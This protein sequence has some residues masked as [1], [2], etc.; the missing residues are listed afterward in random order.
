MRG[1]AELSASLAHEIKNPLA[2]IRSAVEQ[3]AE[4]DFAP[5]LPPPG[6]DEVGWL[7]LSLGRMAERIGQM[8]Q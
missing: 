1:I 5:W 3:I 2:S 8:M 6:K 7:S 4:G